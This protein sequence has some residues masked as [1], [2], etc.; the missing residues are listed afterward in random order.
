VMNN[1]DSV[2]AAAGAARTAA[3]ATAEL[4]R[5]NGE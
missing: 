2:A 5:R 1:G 3:S 4:V